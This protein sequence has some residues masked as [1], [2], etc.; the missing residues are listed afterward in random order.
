[1]VFR[2]EE[3]AVQ[4]ERVTAAEADLPPDPAADAPMRFIS[5]PRWRGPRPPRARIQVSTLDPISRGGS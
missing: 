4:L 2:D 3:F 1:M 5:G